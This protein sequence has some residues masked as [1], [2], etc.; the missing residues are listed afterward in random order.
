MSEQ[1]TFIKVDADQYGKTTVI[2]LD[3]LLADLARDADLPEVTA[4]KEAG[5]STCIDIRERV[6]LAT[7][8]GFT[9]GWLD[10]AAI[11]GVLGLC[12]SELESA[13]EQIANDRYPLPAGWVEDTDP[14]PHGAVTMARNSA[15]GSWA[16]ITQ[17]GNVNF[18]SD[19]PRA[20]RAWLCRRWL[21]WLEG[22]TANL[23]NSGKGLTEP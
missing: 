14:M 8:I 3:A 20:V 6:L 11:D 4:A 22:E 9:I 21:D 18:W 7:A 23:E 19:P 12:A 1:D 5:F 2:V 16:W 15:E 13:V 10:K 17:H